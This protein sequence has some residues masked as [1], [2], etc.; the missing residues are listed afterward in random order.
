MDVLL[1]ECGAWGEADDA[2]WGA[3]EAGT[4]GGGA[5]WIRLRPPSTCWARTYEPIVAREWCRWE[6]S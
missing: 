5:M 4:A 6:P 1:V 2:V 3:D